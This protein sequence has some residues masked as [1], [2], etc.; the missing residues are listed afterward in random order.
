MRVTK[1][2]DAVAVSNT[3]TTN[4]SV[5]QMRMQNDEDGIVQVQIPSG[6]PTA[7]LKVQG[8]IT[9]DAPWVD[10]KLDAVTNTQT[11]ASGYWLIPIFP[12]MRMSVT[13]SG[14]AG[15]TTVDAWIGD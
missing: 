6:G 5:V 8:R 9:S 4:S 11:N 1:F 3:G 14:S 13:G 12:E 7:T 2:F 15:S 10:I